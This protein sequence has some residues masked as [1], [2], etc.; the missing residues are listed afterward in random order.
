MD[1]VDGR[2]ELVGGVTTFAAMA[3][4][5][6]VN[7]AIL[8]ETGMDRGALITATALASAIM[9]TVMALATNYPIALAP[10]M[11]INAFFTFELV[12]GKA[13]APEA[14]LGLVV[15]S[16]AVFL[17]LSL[18]P[19]RR[20]VARA[21]PVH[22]RQAI[23]G[24]IGMFL[25]FIGLKNAGFIA[26]HPATL[27]TLGTLDLRHLLF[28]GGLLLAAGLH[29][30][31]KPYAFLASI[32][33]TTAA[34]LALPAPAHL[35]PHEW[36][37]LP[38]R[39]AQA[40]DL[41]LVFAADIGSALRV[42]LIPPLLTL[43][44]T[45]LFDSLS[46]F[47][48]VAQAA[49]LLDEDGEPINLE[50]ALLV[51]ATATLASGL[52]GTSPATTYVESTAGVEAGG[53]TGWTAVVA[54]VAFLP[55]AF[56]AP[57][58]EVVPAFATAPILVLVGALMA[59]STAGLGERPLEER[60]PAFLVMIL[61]PL[62]FSITSGILWGLVLH[63]LLFVLA[64]RR[65]ALRRMTWALFGVGVGLLVLEHGALLR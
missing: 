1:L 35:A 48:G 30:A 63:P 24:G 34:A 6:A 36:A 2:R 19:L 22:L 45:D 47:L 55:F 49:D 9:T 13:I 33:A 57:L 62:T 12:K 39:L 27:V 28:L 50:R 43:L 56:L 29:R 17:A 61:I 11:G 5:L 38:E 7:P 51:D 59:R 44:F 31:G 10:G 4:I 25:A 20:E 40:P 65:G 23:G 16:G 42:S 26:D 15:L 8:S 53:R 41:S 54:G 64:G 14:A 32:G 37:R 58:V 18:T 60:L 21:I 46:T 3:Y 52:V